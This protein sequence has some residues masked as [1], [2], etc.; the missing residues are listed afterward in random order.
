[1][2]RKILIIDDHDD[3]STRLR[4][5]FE[6][7]GHTVTVFSDHDAALE[8]CSP[9]TYDLVVT[10]LDVIPGV[11]V[12]TAI[13]VNGRPLFRLFKISACGFTQTESLAEDLKQFIETVLNYKAKELDGTKMVRAIRE[14]VEIEIPSVVE[15]LNPILSY[16]TERVEKL[17]VIDS[18]TSNLFV[19]LDEAFANAIR[20]GNKLDPSKMVRI[21]ADL[22][23]EEA[24]FTIE[25]EGE[26]FD[27]SSIPDPRDPMNL[28]KASGRGV[29]FISSIM[30]EVRYNERGN[31]ITM[32]KRTDG[33]K[34]EG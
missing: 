25:D 10:D 34:T 15:L 9:G 17:G 28:M 6:A 12:E 21:A 24:S 18:S 11:G 27:V 14:I 32:V 30:D 1:M 26:G 19:A 33:E 4:S 31:K 29:F 16:L 2:Q 23:V 7:D 8:K 13:G 20:H 3:L 22:S 5:V